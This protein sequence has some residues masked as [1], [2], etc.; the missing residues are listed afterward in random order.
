MG[1][2]TSGLETTWIR[3]TSAIER[4]VEE[5]GGWTSSEEREEGRVRCSLEICTEEPRDEHLKEGEE[6]EQEGSELKKE[7]E[8]RDED[9]PL[10][11]G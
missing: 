2:R 3:N 8:R 7:G 9:E 1:E 11:F 10:P 5:S 6:S 4:L